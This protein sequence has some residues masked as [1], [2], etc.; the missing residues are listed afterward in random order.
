LKSLPQTKRTNLNLLK[1]KNPQL[2]VPKKMKELKKVLKKTRE[3]V[4]KM[5]TKEWLTAL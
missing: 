3:K 4:L 5:K 2:K 1:A